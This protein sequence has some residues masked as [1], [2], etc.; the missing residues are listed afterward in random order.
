MLKPLVPKFR[1]DLS[2]RLRDI[3][4]KQ[5]IAKPKP[6]VDI[7]IQILIHPQHLTGSSQMNP[8]HTLGRAGQGRSEEIKTERGPGQRSSTHIYLHF[9][10]KLLTERANFS[11]PFVPR[12]EKLR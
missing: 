7:G 11:C 2:V 6:I 5:V 9:L 4:E 1:S 12:S 10:Q 3:A 8:Y